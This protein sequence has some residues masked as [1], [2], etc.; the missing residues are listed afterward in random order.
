[1]PKNPANLSLP[2]LTRDMLAFEQGTAFSLEIDVTSSRNAT[3]QIRG[4]TREGPFKVDQ[5]TASGITS[6]SYSFRIPDIPLAL[7]ITAVTSGKDTNSVYVIAHLGINGDRMLILCQGNV[8]KKFGINYPQ[9]VVDSPMQQR[10]LSV[11]VT[12]ADPAANTETFDTLNSLTFHRLIS[13][14][15]EFVTGAAAATRRPSLQIDDGVSNAIIIP[16]AGDVII[17][18]TWILQ[19]GVGLANLVDT[20]GKRQTM[21]LPADLWLPPGAGVGTVT[22]ALNALDN[23]GAPLIWDERFGGID[24]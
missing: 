5:V 11:V 8:S 4:F 6:V 2:Y 9:Q 15:V 18:E 16:S 24:S 1:M 10:G 22:T 20:T 3:I 19:W 23:Y 21:P 7:S 12:G 13:Y 17:S 14:R